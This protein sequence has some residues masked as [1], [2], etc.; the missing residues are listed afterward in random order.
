MFVQYT[1]IDTFTTR[2]FPP[3]V[4]GVDSFKKL[5]VDGGAKARMIRCFGMSMQYL[6]SKEFTKNICMDTWQ[7]NGA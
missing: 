5:R 1:K 7:G 4:L 2:P 6:E 3:L